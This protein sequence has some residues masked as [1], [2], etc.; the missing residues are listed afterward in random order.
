MSNR[1]SI[2]TSSLGCTSPIPSPPGKKHPGMSGGRA[3]S[4]QPAPE[5]VYAQA[6]DHQQAGA[7]LPRLDGLAQQDGGTEEAEDGHQQRE[8]H[9]GRHGILRQESAPD[10]ISE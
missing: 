9:D 7:D 6:R 4:E 3:P 10:R 2:A 1:V 5:Q 8:R